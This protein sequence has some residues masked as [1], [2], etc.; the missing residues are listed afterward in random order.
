MSI[1]KFVDIFK[2]SHNVV[3]GMLH[4]EALPG[5]PR[6]KL[7]MSKICDVALREAEIY[8]NAGLDAVM[9]ENMHDVPYV[10]SSEFGPEVVAAMAT[11]A[12]KL[13]HEF[14]HTPMGIQILTTGNKEALSIAKCVG[15]NFIRAEGLV[16]SHIGD[17]GWIDSNAGS[18]LRYQRTINAEDVLIF[19][20]IKKKHCSH[21]VTS[22]IDIS[23]TARALEFFLVD[24]AIVT[25]TETSSPADLQDFN[26]VS[27][28][29]QIPVLIGSGVTKS[30]V[31]KFLSANGLVIG[32]HFKTDGIW[33]NGVD[34]GRV[35]A[36]MREINTLRQDMS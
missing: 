8:V 18:L 15:L 3:V 5:S 35:E 7:P 19:G 23:T 11:V 1:K 6:N 30:N 29:I 31:H 2:R 33:Y 28:A 4:L 21:S 13:R 25:G 10:K 22:D 20:D 34:Q 36:F 14:P 16:F 12:T 17:E 24:G 26:D 27:A 9:I 32:S